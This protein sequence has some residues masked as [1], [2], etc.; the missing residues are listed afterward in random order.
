M[1]TSL[2]S[3]SMLPRNRAQRGAVLGMCIQEG[4]VKEV[5]RAG[6]E[7]STLI[8]WGP[9]ESRLKQKVNSPRVKKPSLYILTP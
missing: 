2:L 3:W 7:L 6:E 5:C 4:G 8:S 1:Q 9:L